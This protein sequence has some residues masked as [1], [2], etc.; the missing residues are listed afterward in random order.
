VAET[1]ASRTV[2]SAFKRTVLWAA[3]LEAELFASLTPSI[4]LRNARR[5][6]TPSAASPGRWR[7]ISSEHRRAISDGSERSYAP[8]RGG[9]PAVAQL[10]MCVAG[11]HVR[12]TGQVVSAGLG[13]WITR[14]VLIVAHSLRG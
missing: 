4:R 14:E 5:S 1:Q 7:S 2:R 8:F 10:E 12:V 6:W 11:L 9:S 13:L 3:R